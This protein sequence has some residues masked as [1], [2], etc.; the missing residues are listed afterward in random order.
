MTVLR[1]LR[2]KLRPRQA[3]LPSVP[4]SVSFPSG[5]CGHNRTHS[6]T[7]QDTQGA[8]QDVRVWSSSRWCQWARSSMRLFV[9]WSRRSGESGGHK[10]ALMVPKQAL[11]SPLGALNGR[12]K[13]NRIKNLVIADSEIP[14]WRRGLTDTPVSRRSVSRPFH[15]QQD[16]EKTLRM[17]LLSIC[18]RLAV[19]H[20]PHR[21]SYRRPS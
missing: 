15:H 2:C 18:L 5:R 20:G 1:A 19:V 11:P 10:G 16:S 4:F 12:M 14:W 21:S 17:N 3:S 9:R 8:E 6:G 7:E 13:W